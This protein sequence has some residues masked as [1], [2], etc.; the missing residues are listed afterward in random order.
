MP[1]P[2]I[3]SSSTGASTSACNFGDDH[4]T[5]RMDLNHA[6]SLYDDLVAAGFHSPVAKF[7][8]LKLDSGPLESRIDVKGEDVAVRVNLFHVDLTTPDTRQGLVD[9]YEAAMKN[10]DVVIYDGHAG[11]QLDYSGI[12]FAYHPA[13]VSL[14]ADQWKGVESTS[15]QQVYLF[16]GCETYTGYADSLYENPLKNVDN[17]DVITTG[18]FSAIQ[19]GA[20]QVISFIHSFVDQKSGH[21]VPRSW[22]S[23]L[24]KMNAVGER[25]WVHVYGVHGIDDDPKASPLADASKV[26]ASCTKD[27]DCGAVDSKCVRAGNAHVCGMACADS[28]GCPAGTQC[29]LPS[30]ARSVDDRQCVA[31]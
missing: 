30:N 3:W 9:V 7:E 14:P 6:R 13:R 11:R 29:V 12:V 16:N 5:P 1:T 27:S 22:D 2:S 28:A 17:T 19:N 24:G 23:V 8:D 26:G 25:S 21:W 10:A 20:N 31:R 4:N 18:N 15:K